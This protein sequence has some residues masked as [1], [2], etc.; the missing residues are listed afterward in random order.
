M[1]NLM[2]THDK[3][4]VDELFG[5]HPRGKTWKKRITVTIP[6]LPPVLQSRMNDIWQSKVT[7]IQNFPAFIHCMIE[8]AAKIPLYN[9]NE[10]APCSL[11]AERRLHHR[12]KH[13]LKQLMGYSQGQSMASGAQQKS[14][15]TPSENK[16][17]FKC[18]LAG[19]LRAIAPRKE[20][21]RAMRS[22]SPINRRRNL[23]LPRRILS[24][25]TSI[26][27]FD[28]IFSPKILPDL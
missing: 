8:E 18:G 12:S 3:V 5:L 23:L 19:N 4:E 13:P 15:T 7:T 16:M 22:T 2:T 27:F 6:L 17:C 24:L 20:G 10:V 14:L 9:P 28:L 1:L 26:Q 25:L 21:S 11:S